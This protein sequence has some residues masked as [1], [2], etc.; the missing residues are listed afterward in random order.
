MRG[1]R[2]GDGV[3]GSI[4]NQPIE[5]DA[6]IAPVVDERFRRVVQGLQIFDEAIALKF[7]LLFL[8]FR[9][10][11]FFSNAR[12]SLQKLLKKEDSIS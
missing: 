3:Q 12:F 6:D 7:E 2:V 11:S 5:K 8:I 4:F 1:G 10:H 9:P